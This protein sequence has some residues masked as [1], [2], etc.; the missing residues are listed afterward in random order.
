MAI[1][2][3]LILG[4]FLGFNSFIYSCITPL[5]LP[6]KIWLVY[7]NLCSHIG[8]FCSP[9]NTLRSHMPLLYLLHLNSFY[10]HPTNSL[11]L[12]CHPLFPVCYTLFSDYICTNICTLHKYKNL[13]F[14]I[15]MRQFYLPGLMLS[16]VTLRSVI[17]FTSMN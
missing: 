15:M 4:A 17:G 6:C 12:T 1:N 16:K 5:H 11:Y 3:L 10:E 13:R 8:P 9:S 2:A 14:S 7:I